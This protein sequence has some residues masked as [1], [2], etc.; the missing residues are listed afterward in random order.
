[1]SEK[2]KERNA[3]QH[4]ERERERESYDFLSMMRFDSTTSSFRN[5]LVINHIEKNESAK[6][7][8]K[9]SSFHSKEN[10]QKHF[11]SLDFCPVTHLQDLKSFDGQ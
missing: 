5:L 1:M 10:V 9:V 8:R 4:R 11:L 3:S 2:E 6:F 7:Q